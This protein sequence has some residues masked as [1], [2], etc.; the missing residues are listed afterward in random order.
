LVRR[1]AYYNAASNFDH[2]LY[3][4]VF[5]HDFLS[6]LKSRAQLPLGRVGPAGLVN[7]G[8]PSMISMPELAIEKFER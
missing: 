6:W 8:E 2:Y 1:D 4:F 7:D 3:R 5:A